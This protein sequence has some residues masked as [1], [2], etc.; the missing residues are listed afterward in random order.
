[1]LLSAIATIGAYLVGS[2]PTGYLVTRMARG[3]DI[4]TVGS[5]NIGA[6]NVGRVLGF[7]F[8]ALV[9]LIDFLK[10]LGPTLGFPV[11]ITQAAGSSPPGLAV[12]VAVAAILGHNFPVFLA[13]RGGKGVATSLG[14]VA[15]LDPLACL[16]A[17]L[18]FAFI[19]VITRIVSLS[20]MLA[21][22]MF[23]VTHFS[24]LDEPW[25]ASQSTLSVAILVL[26]ALLFWRH[27][28]N[29]VR[30]LRGSEPRIRLRPPR[31]KQGSP[32]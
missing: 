3:I 21:A 17:A 24:R 27:R 23:T 31:P 10:G 30:I 22:L 6:T 11:L 1:L 25:A 16:V 26:L 8:F 7:R 19:L 32:A 4:R 9:F 15:A 2:I 5:G 14:A 18:A 29:V 20:S 12:A 13:F 28:A